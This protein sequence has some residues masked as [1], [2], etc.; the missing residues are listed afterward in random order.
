MRCLLLTL[1]LAFLLL[2]AQEG[3]LE[4][5]FYEKLI[6]EQVLL[7]SQ[8]KDFSHQGIVYLPGEPGRLI[9]SAKHPK[10]PSRL[11]IHTLGKPGFRSVLLQ[12]GDGLIEGGVGGLAVAG[13]QLVIAHQEQRA[14]IGRLPLAALDA[15]ADGARLVP[16]WVPVPGRASTC[17]VH[18]GQLWILPFVLPEHKGYGPDEASTG[19]DADGQRRP[20]ALALDLSQVLS[21]SAGDAEP[22]VVDRRFIP[23]MVQGAAFATG[24]WW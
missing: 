16:E 23:H 3:P 13:D 7:R 4:Q 17:A 20:Q 12:K 9:L 6:K 8:A 14:W 11:E 18:A 24:S 22:P 5:G 2:P 10:G 1:V 15:A 21:W 19:V